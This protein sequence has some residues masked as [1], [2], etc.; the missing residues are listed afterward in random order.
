M[1]TRPFLVLPN[2]VCVPLEGV[3]RVECHDDQWYV[4]GHNEVHP[5]RSQNEAV[6]QLERLRDDEE[7]HR[8]AGQALEG[9]TE[10]FDISSIQA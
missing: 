3:Y 7:A 9:L 6:H 8:L 2:Q 1:P 10:E 5:A 4:L